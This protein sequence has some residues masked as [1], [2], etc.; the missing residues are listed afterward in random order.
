MEA[1]IINLII[2]QTLLI[3]VMFL[4]L[5]FYILTLISIKFK[6]IPYKFK[7]IPDIDLPTVTVQIPVYNDPVA[8]R[9]IKKCLNFDYPKNKYDIVI[10]DDSN[11]GMTTKIIKNFIKGKKNVKLITRN[12][13]EG[14]KSGA[15]N[16]ATKYSNGEIIVIFDSDFIPKKDFLR[17]IVSPLVTDNKLAFVQSRMDYINYNHNIISKFAAALLM[18]YHNCI[19]PISSR[20]NTVFFCG[21]HGA[22]RKS[23]LLEC[24][25]WNENSI[26]EDADLSMKIFDKGYTSLYV[27]NLKVAGEVPFTLKSFLK[28]QMRW[29]YGITRVFMDHW[30][31]I[32]FGK[33]SLSQKSMLVFL[34]MGHVMTLFVVGAFVSGQLGWIL[35]PPKP[36]TFYDLLN[37]LIV[38]GYTSGFVSI[39]ALALHRDNKIKDF[40][41]LFGASMVIGMVLSFANLVSFGKAIVGIRHGWVRTPKMASVAI[42]EFF[43]RLLLR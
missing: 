10:A 15:L 41:R 12:N 35:T 9:C 5:L 8:V 25:G 31:K 17:K 19:M 18:I 6:H 7:Q 2:Y 4:S 20:L 37:F 38:I 30:R 3:P 36:F 40:F 14:F 27:S 11:D 43:K 34:T 33:F 32:F 39:G 13:R 26:T 42:L 24:D 16:N 1:Y 28:Q 22:I 21:T 29:S 23:V